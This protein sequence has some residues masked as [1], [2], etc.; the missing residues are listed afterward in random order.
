MGLLDLLSN[1]DLGK[2]GQTPEK[3]AGASNESTLHYQS[4]INGNPRINRPISSLDL[5]GKTPE[6]YTDNLPR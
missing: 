2:K 3:R 6:K 4:S 1:S 5:D